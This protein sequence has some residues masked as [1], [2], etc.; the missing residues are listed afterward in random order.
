MVET[1]WKFDFSKVGIMATINGAGCCLIYTY[2]RRENWKLE[3]GKKK[4]EK[5]GG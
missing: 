3:V 1:N 5:R 2:I 4:K